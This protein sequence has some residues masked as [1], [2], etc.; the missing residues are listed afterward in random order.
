VPKN[1]TTT[2]LPAQ[3]KN[4]ALILAYFLLLVSVGVNIVQAAHRNKESKLAKVNPYPLLDPAREFI[5]DKD[6]IT[7]IQELR[8]YL[9]ELV[10]KE[11][12]NSI[13]IY[14]EM[15]TTGANITVNNDLHVWP[16]SL[17]KLPIALA[18][19]KK[20]EHGTWDWQNE[21]V[22]LPEDQES[23]SGELY[24]NAV[25]TRFSIEKLV[26]K[27][28]IDSDNTAYQIL[29]RNLTED[30]LKGLVDETGLSDLLDKEGKFSAKEYSRLFRVLYTA[31]YL[32]KDNSQKFLGWLAQAKFT[33]F[34]SQGIP[35]DVPLAHKYGENK[36]LNVFSDSGIVYLQY[37][38]Y[39]LTVMIQGQPGD[40]EIAKQKAQKVF[41]LASEN[42]F[43]QIKNH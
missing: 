28:L 17:V 13:S 1:Q 16:A 20:V 26:Q 14:F 27:A 40:P 33:E 11:G 5:A 32:N 25:G 42:A 9:N 30:D 36:E 39:L 18:A 10:A 34:L 22:L 21:L 31:S 23:H 12:P 19:V 15:L 38:P 4:F 43:Q 3:R 6:S 7:N 29:N 8:E 2:S 41:K 37:R 24:K 35:P